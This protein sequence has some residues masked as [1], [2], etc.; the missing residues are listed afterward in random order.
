LLALITGVA[1]VGLLLMG[2]SVGGFFD[3]AGTTV[4]ALGTDLGSDGRGDP[5]D[6]GETGNPHHPGETGDPH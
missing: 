6:E 5:H 3:R 2:G 4:R 1:V